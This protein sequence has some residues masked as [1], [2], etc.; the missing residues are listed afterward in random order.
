M[1]FPLLIA[2]AVWAFAA[3]ARPTMELSLGAAVVY[4]AIF[5]SATQVSHRRAA[6]VQ[7]DVGTGAAF[8]VVFYLMLLMPDLYSMLAA[9]LDPGGRQ[10]DPIDYSASVVVAMLA[11]F[12]GALGALGGL[13]AGF[14]FEHA[15]RGCKATSD[16][17]DG[18]E[19]DAS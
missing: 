8:G 16:Y 10:S 4:A 14:V 11:L 18:S 1:L 2:P 9:C 7:R 15:W 13:I 12:H 5:M 17:R 6:N 19:H 3:V